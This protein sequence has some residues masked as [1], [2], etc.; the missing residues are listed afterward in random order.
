MKLLIQIEELKDYRS[1][2]N[3]PLECE[4]CHNT[5]FR[6][7]ND[8][9]RELKSK[10]NSLQYCSRK[11]SDTQKRKRS[12][13]KCVNCGKEFV[14][15]DCQIN[16]NNFCNQS[17]SAEYNNTHKTTGYRRSKL[18]TWIEKEL[19]KIYPTLEVHYNKT[20]A[21][22]DELDIYVPSLNLAFE[23]NGIFHYEPIYS[24]EKFEK[25]KRN[26]SRKFQ[27]CLEKKIGLCV[28]DT[29]PL[30]YFKEDKAKKYLDIVLNLIEENLK[31]VGNTGIEPVTQQCQC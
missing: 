12:K 23:L 31:M 17:C 3:V 21:I 22:E 16:K 5:F 10:I 2:D 26:D 9:L 19:T 28:I 6:K 29:S 15:L 1:R 30:V 24:Q 11:C 27:K 14:R 7:K 18:E 25:T 4:F 8:V 13:I 20:N